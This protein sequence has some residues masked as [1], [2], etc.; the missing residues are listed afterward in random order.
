MPIE[1]A[2]CACPR[3]NVS[4]VVLEPEEDPIPLLSAVNLDS[5]ESV[6]TSVLAERLGTLKDERMQ[7]V[8]AALAVTTDCG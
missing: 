7:Q 5:V 4:R 8:C 2:G 6:S 3:S 1:R